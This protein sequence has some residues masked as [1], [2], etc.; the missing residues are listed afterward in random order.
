MEL[1]A[2]D[3]IL[4]A[5]TLR[6]ILESKKLAQLGDFLA[7]F[8]YS[9]VT[10]GNFDINGSVHVWDRSLKEA[11]E[12]ANLRV[13]M[14]KKVKPDKVADAAEAL[15]AFAYFR[16]LVSLEEMTAMIHESLSTSDLSSPR[17]E[18]VACADAF[19]VVLEKIIIQAENEGLVKRL[20]LA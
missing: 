17:K 14:G 2:L 20:H 16:N 10:I 3:P 5:S 9:S 6:D 18:K 8:V 7:N 1:K 19:C 11:M 13:E 15:I 12:K 4:H